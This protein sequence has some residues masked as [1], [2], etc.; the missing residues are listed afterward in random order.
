MIR[1]RAVV[2]LMAA[3]IFLSLIVYPQ[4]AKCSDNN[5]W[6]RLWH[7][8]LYC[9]QNPVNLSTYTV[10][11]GANGHCKTEVEVVLSIFHYQYIYPYDNLYFKL[12]VYVKASADPGYQPQF[13]SGVSIHLDKMYEGQD[14]EK[15][16]LVQ[17]QGDPGYSQGEGVYQSTTIAS[18]ETDYLKLA[19]KGLAILSLAIEFVAS[20]IPP[21]V[22]VAMGMIGAGFAFA[23]EPSVD[24]EDA[25][26]ND[27]CAHSWWHNEA[28][29]GESSPI[30]QYCFNCFSWKQDPYY[31]LAGTYTLYVS[32][33]I[34]T[35]N[36]GVI[37]S[38]TTNPICLYIYSGGGGGCPILSV[39]DGSG[40]ACEGLLNIH[41][42]DRI[43]VVTDHTLTA[44]PEAVDG[45]YLLRLREHPM[46]TSYIDQVK[47]YALFGDGRYRVPLP[48]VA[49]SH[50]AH[51]NVLPQLLF[52][53]NWR[54]DT[55]GARHND[56]ESES[57]GLEFLALPP[58]I[59]PSG[60]V[61]RTEGYND[62]WK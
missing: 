51:G 14:H 32:A 56:G 17:D 28:F 42:T 43:D 7:D 20:E 38:F 55:L 61:F 52:S 23:P 8:Y 6:G 27:A 33:G 60:F 58:G 46:T 44:Q 4:P 15:I 12:A 13:A 29:L 37:P 26:Y 62:E 11:Y 34:T 22:P 5:F 30:R 35:W 47:L 24:F 45:K 57:I 1:K 59:H 25:G 31:P 21:W 19:G 49:A 48:L 54:I 3:L 18:G 10:K 41:N 53:D 2:L 40:Y 36:P 50:S 9:D 39:F 16:Q